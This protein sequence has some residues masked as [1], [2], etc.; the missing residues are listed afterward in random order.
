MCAGPLLNPRAGSGRSSKCST[1]VNNQEYLAAHLIFC[2]FISVKS[3]LPGSWEAHCTLSRVPGTPLVWGTPSLSCFCL[4][5]SPVTLTTN[6][7]GGRG[8][9]VPHCSKPLHHF[10]FPPRSRDRQSLRRGRRK[11]GTSRIGMC[12]LDHHFILQHHS[13]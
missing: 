3:W 12:Y 5:R 13:S 1:C 11:L 4:G 9:I 8:G 2:N 7:N 10:L 6:S